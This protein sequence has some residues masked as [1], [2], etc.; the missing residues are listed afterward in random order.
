MLGA[1]QGDLFKHSEGLAEQKQFG[2]TGLEL[3]KRPFRMWH[4]FEEHEDRKR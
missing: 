2:T 1:P 3:T 4:S